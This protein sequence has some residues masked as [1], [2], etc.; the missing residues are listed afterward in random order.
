MDWDESKPKPVIAVGDNL[1]NLSVL[2]LR[3][4]IEA[5]RA[6]I[7]RIEAAMTAKQSTQQAAEDVFKRSD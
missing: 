7:D 5:L 1:A 3:E 6:E 2:D 4:R